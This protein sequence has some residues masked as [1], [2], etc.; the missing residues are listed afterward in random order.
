MAT[1]EP[2]LE[3]TSDHR[4]DSLPLVDLRLLSQPE[5]YTLSLSGATH[6]HRRNS[7]DDSVIPKIDR[8]NFNESAGSRKQTYSKLR[9]NKRKQNPAVPASSS[10]HIPLHIS[11]PEEEENSRIVALLQQLFGVEPLRN[12]PRN[13]AAE[14]RLVPVQVDFKQPPPMFA[15]FQNVPID[16]V[17]DGSQRKRKRGRPRKD[18]NSVTVFVEEPKKVTKEENSVTV[19]VEEPK[20]VNG[21]GEVNAAVATTTTTVGLDEDPFEVVLKRRTQ[22]LETEPQVVEFLET[23]NGEWASQRKKRRIVPASEL[24]DLLPAGWK[25]VIITMRRAGRASAVCRRYV[26]P[27][28]HQ[29]ESCKKASAYLLSVFG[30]QDRSHLKSSY[31]DGAQQLSSSMN[32]ASESSVGHVPTGDM[33]TDASASYLPSAGAPIHSSHDKQ[34]PISSSIGSENFNSDLALGCKLGDATGGAFRDFDF[35][36]EDKKLSKADKDDGNSV[37]ECFVEDRVCNVQSEKLVGAVESSDAACN[38]YIPLVFSTPFSNNNSDNGQFLDE[39]NASRCMKG[40]ISNFASHDRDTGCCETV[41]CGNEQ[42]HVDNN[43][44]GLSVKLV[45]ENIQKLSF[46]SSML[47]PNSEGKIHAGKNLEDGHLISSLEDMEIRDGKAIMNDKQQIICS[48]D[49]TE[50]KDVSTDVKLHS[51]S[52]GCSLVSSHHEL[53]TSTSN[54][55]RTQTSELKDSAEENIFD[56]DLFSSSIDERTRVHSGYISNVSFSSCTQDASEYGG[57]DFASDLKLDKDVSDNHILSNEEAVTRCLRERSSLNDQNSMMDNL[58]HR[59]SESN[60]F[61]LTG[62]QH[63]CAFHDN[64]NISDG[65][66]DALKV[67]DAGCMEPQLGIV[68]CS[69]IAVD[70][71]T[72]ASIMQGKPQGCVSVPLGGS[73]LNF[74]KPSDDGVNKA[75]KSCLPETA[76]NEVEMFQTDSMGLPKFR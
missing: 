65:T 61:A 27:D 26:S 20:K 41:S 76:Q 22:G 63:S 17:A 57:F 40:G 32:R 55:D 53:N 58:L 29:F 73:I 36:T 23:L 59:S 46:E 33:K 44:L 35:Q 7:D 34:P 21:N 38:L 1:P 3:P 54:M 42:A 64:V 70:A 19:F 72:T 13:D 2:Q 4:V 6:C 14:R 5:L 67:V 9:L 18:E 8:S 75:N 47:A 66:F 51:S 30:V 31:S 69:N 62:N 16:V 39:I 68:S 52:E 24:G 74:E 25:I 48:R 37:Q 49:Q 43:G 56:S 45:E 12:A 15:A 28:G 50:I 11:E 60:L 71:Y 10:F